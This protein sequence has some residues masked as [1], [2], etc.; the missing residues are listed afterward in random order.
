MN[1]IKKINEYFQD[2]PLKPLDLV[3]ILFFTLAITKIYSLYF[4]VEDEEMDWE[5]F[6][7]KNNCKLKLDED[8]YQSSTW[9]CDDGKVHY[10]WRQ[11]R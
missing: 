6:R 10:G 5:T 7:V 2:S 8:G 11:Q 9:V 1:V 4:S 3:L